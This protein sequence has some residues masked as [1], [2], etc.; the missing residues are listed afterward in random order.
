MLFFRAEAEAQLGPKT[1]NIKLDLYHWMRRWGRNIGLHKTGIGRA[2]RRAI[3]FRLFNKHRRIDDIDR[4]R[5]AMADLR[6]S[7]AA[8]Q[9]AEHVGEALFNETCSAPSAGL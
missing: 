5:D 7:A 1:V 4:I 6:T 3:V 9:I 8:Q 2:L